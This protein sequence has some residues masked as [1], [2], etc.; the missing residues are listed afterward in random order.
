[1]CYTQI[2]ETYNSKIVN[3]KKKFEEKRYMVPYATFKWGHNRNIPPSELNL[4]LKN[5]VTEI[6]EKLLFPGN[7]II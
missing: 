1:M 6:R 7:R 3:Y 5:K 4:K 2:L